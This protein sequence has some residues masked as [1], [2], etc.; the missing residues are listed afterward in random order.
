MTDLDRV[1]AAYPSL[2]DETPPAAT[3]ARLQSLYADALAEPD[4]GT[5][6]RGH[7]R[8]WWSSRRLGVLAIGGVIV[9]G[10]A[11]AATIGGWHPL[12]GSPDRGPRPLAANTGVP[13]DQRAALAVLRRPQTNADRGPL[14]EKALRVLDRR[15]INGIHTDA[16]R[17]ISHGPRE[18]AVLVP[19]DRVGPHIE[20]VPASISIQRHVLCLMATSYSDA[21]TMTITQ[22]GK[23][24]TIRFPAGYT[25]WGVICGGLD[26]LRT[27]GIQAGTSPDASGGLI[28]NGLPKHPA[29]HRVTLVPDGVARVTV[30]LRHKRTVTVPVHDNV[31][32]Y[33]IHDSPAYMGTI[34]FDA[35]GHRI[36]HHKHR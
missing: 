10:T 31:Y 9:A 19:A 1:R 6:T 7:R 30:R 18:L 29:L 14:V 20:G 23:P 24:K 34:W 33:T 21:R 32:R 17:V 16:I 25:G 27:T 3:V 8:R 22:H 2:P 4:D 11:I 35:A 28:I 5:G 26:T 13:A 15:T 12:L 36:D